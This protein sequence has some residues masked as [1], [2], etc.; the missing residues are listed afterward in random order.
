MSM[1]VDIVKGVLTPDITPC[2]LVVQV[3]KVAALPRNYLTVL[4][5]FSLASSVSE[6]E[7]CAQTW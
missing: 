5:H 1:V 6:T 4:N 7:E 2:D 3:L